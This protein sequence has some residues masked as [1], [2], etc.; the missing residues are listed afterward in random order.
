M[1]IT[2]STSAVAVCCCRIRAGRQCFHATREQ[3][4]VLDGD[5]GLGRKLFQQG[6]LF[7]R[8][9]SFLLPEDHDVADDTFLLDQRHGEQTA[10]TAEVN[11][12][13]AIGFA[14]AIGVELDEVGQ[15][16]NR[17]ALQQARG[18]SA[19]AVCHRVA[20]AVLVVG[21]RWPP[22]GGGMK[23]LTVERVEGAEVRA[24]KLHCLAKHGVKN[25]RKVAGGAADNAQDLRGGGL[26][27]KRLSKVARPCLH[28]IEQI[29]IRDGNH[30]LVRKHRDRLDLPRRE[31]P[32][33]RLPTARS[34]R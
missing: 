32:E 29:D 7:V 4:R 12:R 21:G 30:G 26:L 1:L 6:D 23:Q 8:K 33:M 34:H 9:A 24:T 22:G 19:R 28:L 2:L 13:A 18:R 20:A 11:E 5:D 25:G 17:L 27:L 14:A 3:P 15:F 10:G 16:D 31:W